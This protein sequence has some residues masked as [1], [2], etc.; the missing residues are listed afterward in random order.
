[1]LIRDALDEKE[2]ASRIG[3]HVVRLAHA[4]VE[5][6][7]ASLRLEIAK[8]HERDRTPYDDDLAEHRISLELKSCRRA[9]ELMRISHLQMLLGEDHDGENPPAPSVGICENALGVGETGGQ[10]ILESL[11]SAA[12]R[13]E[14][15]VSG[16]EKLAR[17]KTREAKR[18]LRGLESRD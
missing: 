8:A 14:S 16:Y 9:V 11:D 2:W 13:I 6:R 12:M 18:I 1:M 7:E 17:R 3:C 4:M 15:R 10:M 5:C